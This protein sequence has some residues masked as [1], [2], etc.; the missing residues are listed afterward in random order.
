MGSASVKISKA[1]SGVTRLYIEAAPL[2][3]YVEEHPKY[4]D[5]M[6]AIIDLVEDTPID[7]VS[8]VISLTEV[9]NQPIRK[10][11]LDLE[12]AYRDILITNDRFQLLPVSQTIAESAA[13]L[14][15]HYNMRTPNALH[16]ATAL[17]ALCDGFLTN[18]NGL[19]RVTAIN[20]L[21]LDDLERDT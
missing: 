1:L 16:V 17:D 4:I 7:V 3:Y 14:R 10:G 9:L 2:I 21:V 15:A 18:D 13:R 19:K 11:R 5:L 12:Q 20:I 8:S 6:E